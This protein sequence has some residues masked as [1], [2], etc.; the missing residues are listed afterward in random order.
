MSDLILTDADL[1]APSNRYVAH[2]VNIVGSLSMSVARTFAEHFAGYEADYIAHSRL[3]TALGR[4]LG[5]TAHRFEAGSQTVFSLYVQ[6]LPGPHTR[7]DWLNTALHLAGERIAR[8]STLH[9]PWIGT[10]T[11]GLTR[12]A[13]AA[14][15]RSAAY[16]T[17]QAIVVHELPSELTD[18]PEILD[19]FDEVRRTHLEH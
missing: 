17:G 4:P 9:V 2:G 18:K 6:G 8:G 13:V 3:W 15:F 14:A 19:L 10:G 11:G 12:S 16:D 1:F 7:L 5:G